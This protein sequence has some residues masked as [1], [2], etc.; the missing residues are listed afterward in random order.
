MKKYLMIS[1]HV[2]VPVL[3]EAASEII[4]EEYSR[5]R[6]QDSINSDVA[7][8]QPI[9][10]RTVETMI[11]LATAHAKAR[12]SRTIDANDAKAAIELVQYAIF[13]KVLDKKEK[14]RRRD[15]DEGETDE[16]EVEEDVVDENEPPPTKKTRSS[17]VSCNS[18]CL[19]EEH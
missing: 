15:E 13:R 17:K 18:L 11:R 9:T 3:T 16:E 10:A 8:T 2:K 19:T 1:K 4:A 12:L 14:K 7:R 5:L 6:S